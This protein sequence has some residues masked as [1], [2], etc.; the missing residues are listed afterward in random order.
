M[1]VA[2]CLCNAMYTAL[3][4]L[5]L[6]CALSSDDWGNNDRGDGGGCDRYGHWVSSFF[7]SFLGLL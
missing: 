1:R 3:C 4:R 5:A 6:F 7:N 2:V